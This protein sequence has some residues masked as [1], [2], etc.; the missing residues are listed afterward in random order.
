MMSEKEVKVK[1]V[2]TEVESFVHQPVLQLATPSILP[3]G[4]L[5]LIFTLF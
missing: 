2:F 4:F 3:C 5:V 1:T